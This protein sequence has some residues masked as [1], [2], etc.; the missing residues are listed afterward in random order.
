M[1]IK[2]ARID[3]GFTQTELAGILAITQTNM[4]LIERGKQT[5]S[6]RT[7]YLLGKVLNEDFYWHPEALYE[8][9]SN[10]VRGDKN[11]AENL[12]VFIDN[13]IEIYKGNLTYIKK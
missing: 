7:R 4:S 12:K 10:Y 3:R 5:A 1:T 13:N 9:I 8:M 6:K 2:E 11:R